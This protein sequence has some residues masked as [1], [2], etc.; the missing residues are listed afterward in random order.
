M[1]R[2]TR[3]MLT[4]ALVM[5]AAVVLSYTPSAG[6]ATVLA[7]EG[8]L[9]PTGTTQRSF[10]GAFCA[11]N[12]CRSINNLRSP[13]DVLP[14]SWQLQAALNATPGKV[15][16]MGFSL[17]AAS[18]YD[19]LRDWERNPELAP[20]PERLT[21]I[22][23]FGNP[24]NKFGGGGRTNPV[25]GLPD[26]QPYQH[27]EVTM[28]YDNVADIPTRWGW[29]S[30]INA[31]FSRHLDYAQPVDINDPE[32]LIYQDPDGTTY[33]LIEAD[34]LPMLKWRDWFTSDE[35]M[36][37]LDAKYRP[38]IEADYDRP[39]YIEQG[40]G[41]DWGNGNPPPSASDPVSDP[42]VVAEPET[43]K[44]HVADDAELTDASKAQGRG[45]ED[46][47]LQEVD[48][49]DADRSVSHSVVADEAADAQESV[50][51]EQPERKAAPADD[52][53]DKH[54]S[55]I[56][57]SDINDGDINDSDAGES[58]AAREGVSAG[59]A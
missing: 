16:L 42:E 20:D 17:G 19:R 15:I 30:M 4:A 39:N 5:P 7:V 29:Y 53:G 2:K 34:V 46:G 52:L 49:G 6:A 36:A 14:A 45:L 1:N 21:L 51:D 27:L 47:Y 25:V 44:P 56:N 18:I 22:V 35:L 54:D 3:R 23:T 48:R 58:D 41:A 26:T 10:S 8:T 33:M 38:L 55:D 57:D 11:Q 28:Q 24:E 32:N 37:E 13:W 59:T 50:E 9:Q 43:R 40:E 12:S 31:A